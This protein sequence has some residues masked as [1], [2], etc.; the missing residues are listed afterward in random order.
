MATNKSQLL[1]DISK[2]LGDLAT[3]VDNI[4]TDL[5]S[6]EISQKKESEQDDDN[7]FYIKRFNE[8]I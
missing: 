8:I 2:T 7:N 4:R 3:L 6:R 5:K 1:F